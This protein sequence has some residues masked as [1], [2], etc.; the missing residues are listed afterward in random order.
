[1]DAVPQPERIYTM[2]IGSSS[3]P[4]WYTP[5]QLK[6]LAQFAVEQRKEQLSTEWGRSVAERLRGQTAARYAFHLNPEGRVE[7][8]F[9]NT[10]AG[11]W[12]MNDAPHPDCIASAMDTYAAQ[13]MPVLKKR[14]YHL[15]PGDGVIAR[16]SLASVN[17]YDSPLGYRGE[18]QHAD[19]CYYH[20]STSTP[21]DRPAGM[22]RGKDGIYMQRT[23]KSD[24][25]DFVP[26]H[27]GE[28]VAFP[29]HLLHSVPDVARGELTIPE[30]GD[31]ALRT[32]LLGFVS[33]NRASHQG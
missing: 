31:S 9:I 11:D 25:F 29:S 6:D 27:R 18:P 17:P 3:H 16:V 19:L 23:P 30:A 4:H 2:T 21:I 24:E 13:V 20:L 28:T 5:Q 15:E 22:P 26:Y 14:G 8:R 32:Q 33:V 1:M 7:K 12:F 10:R